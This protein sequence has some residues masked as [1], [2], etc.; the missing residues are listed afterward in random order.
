[1]AAAAAEMLQERAEGEALMSREQA[2]GL[3]S[4]IDWRSYGRAGLLS[5]VDV[6]TIA[7]AESTPLD[8]TLKEANLARSYVVS[9]V[10]VVG[11]VR[12]ASAQQ[13]AL[14]RLEDVL[15]AEECGSLEE[16]LSLFAGDDGAFDPSPF[17]RSLH[18]TGE[19]YAAKTAASVL[20]TL[21][22][23][24]PEASVEQFVSWLC[25][26]LSSSR[27][28]HSDVRAAVPA[29]TILLRTDR[30]RS[31]FAQHGGVGYVTKL[32]RQ[33][34]LSSANAQ[35]QYEL[36]FCLWTLSFAIESDQFLANASIEALVDQI[37]AAPRE[38]V[39]RVSLAALRNLCAGDVA[40]STEGVAARMIKCGLPKTLRTLRERPW[41]DPDLVDD[42][43]ALNKI[44]V[45]NYRELSSF[46]KYQAEVDGGELD[47]GLVHSETFWKENAKLAEDR[48]FALIKRLVTLLKAEDPKV[49]AVACYDLGEFV[50]FY[51][52]GKAVLKHIGAKDQVVALIEHPDLDVQKHAL[53]CVS[54]MLVT[55][56]E[57]V[58]KS[59]PDKK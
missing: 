23:A 59:A 40:S 33:R 2:L 53:Q 15:T 19:A 47:W 50:R 1:M 5:S 57:F 28:Q 45:S 17:M 49:I 37:A 12:E 11:S 4:S 25:E 31:A 3:Y 13:Y 27:S 52:N 10:K 26:Q 43:E 35:M 16:R 6:D 48:D 8:Y 20:A 42:I 41:T 32:L 46:E 58:T 55:N 18:A 14:T 7:A 56:W 22:S 51:P 29:L 34:D 24:R 54:K 36:T 21:L 38:K 9:L 39:V 44:L 30:A